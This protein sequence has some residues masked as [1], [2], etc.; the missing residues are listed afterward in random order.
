[1]LRQFVA[2][3]DTAKITALQ[4]SSMAA[5]IMTQSLSET[6]PTTQTT[7]TPA[8][9][10]IFC[11]CSETTPTAAIPQCPTHEECECPTTDFFH[12]REN[13]TNLANSPCEAVATGGTTGVPSDDSSGVR[14]QMNGTVVLVV[15]GVV[16][17]ILF[18]VLLAVIACWTWCHYHR[19]KSPPI[20]RSVPLAIIAH[21]L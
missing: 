9:P 5:T 20:E 16:V 2:T 15:L 19:R 12:G 21:A 13:D 11:N 8:T 4:P 1:M 14:G 7:P 10:P 3:D 18:L 17:A 6:T